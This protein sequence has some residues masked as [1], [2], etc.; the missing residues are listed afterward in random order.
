MKKM[1]S[2]LLLI[3][4]LTM[5]TG[6]APT[7]Q[8][9]P[10]QDA[11][12]AYELAQQT[13]AAAL[14]ASALANPTATDTPQP[15]QTNTPQPTATVTVTE[16]MSG[17]ATITKKPTVTPS[18]TAT[19]RPTK[20]PV[21]P[22]AGYAAEF[23]YANTFPALRNEFVPNESFSVG[24]GFKNIGDEPWYPG[25]AMVLVNFKGESTCQ[26]S[27]VLEQTVNPGEKADFSIWGFGSE[28]L[29]RHVWVYQLYAPQGLAIPGGVGVFTYI[30]K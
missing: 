27:V 29:G 30:S 2:F 24:I 19:E 4:A 18:F 9:T 16:T 13:E 23:L 10:T 17:T 22:V 14:T 15:T 21:T 1:A 6:C 7:P 20:T 11:T 5:L 25:T 3:L 12:A 8:P 28:L 26:K